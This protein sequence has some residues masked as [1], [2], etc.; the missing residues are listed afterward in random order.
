MH[1]RS[2]D[3]AQE[4]RI[5]V[6]DLPT[7][8][9][10]WLLAALIGV[11]WL[12]ANADVSW[13]RVHAWGGYAILV[14]VVWRLAWGFLGSPTARFANFLRGPRAA[15]AYARSLLRGEHPVVVGHNPLGGWSVA[16]MLLLLAV[17]AGT[18]LFASDEIL[19]EGPLAHL[20]GSGW[21]AALTAVHQFAFNLLLALVSLH[22]AAVYLYL[23]VGGE[24]LVGPMLSGRK[25]VSPAAAVPDRAFA[26]NRRAL[27]LLLCVAAAVW[28]VVRQ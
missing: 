4:R 15:S 1:D 21:A 22:V 17:Q 14:L 25:R 27:A 24:N 20:V 19:T 10:H 7:R 12:T 5:R 13:M 9:F 3:T 16:A 11:Q 6:W 8:L 28:A 18:G 23:F 2:G 26:G